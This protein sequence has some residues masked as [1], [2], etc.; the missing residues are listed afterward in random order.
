MLADQPSSKLP[1][2]SERITIHNLYA[3]VCKTFPNRVRRGEILGYARLL[4]AEQ[5]GLDLGWTIADN[6]TLGAYARFS[7]TDE[8][9]FGSSEILG[10]TIDSKIDSFNNLAFGASV[11][12][13]F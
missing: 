3:T 8:V 7:G 10:N 5:F 1:F 9:D 13:N 12:L 6:L 4:A 2:P 11:Q